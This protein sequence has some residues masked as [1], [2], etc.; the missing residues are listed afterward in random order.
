MAA[1]TGFHQRW[2]VRPTLRLSTRMDYTSL[3]SVF[4]LFKSIED[5]LRQHPMFA[6][7][8][9]GGE[10]GEHSDGI[11]ATIVLAHPSTPGAAVDEA[12]NR[13]AEACTAAGLMT[14]I[15]KEVVV[16]LADVDPRSL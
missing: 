10:T 15:I 6:G 13:L 11:T 16:E 2:E 7:A 5:A 14:D 1:L 12:T 4:A 3:D 9:V 8:H